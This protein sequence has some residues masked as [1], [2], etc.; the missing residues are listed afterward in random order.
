MK[1]VPT[2]PAGYTTNCSPVE[3]DYCEPGLKARLLA[4]WL[5]NEII[6]NLVC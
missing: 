5:L 3:Q 4:T 2:L 1:S 6:V